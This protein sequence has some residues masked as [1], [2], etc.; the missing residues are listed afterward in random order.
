[1]ASFD[2]RYF[3]AGI[4]RVGTDCEKW[5]GMREETGDSAMIPMWVADLDFPSPPAIR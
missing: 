1:M 5:D 4:N 2:E 3:D